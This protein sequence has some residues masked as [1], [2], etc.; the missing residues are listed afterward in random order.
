[1][2]KNR[3]IFIEIVS[4]FL[5][6]ALVY[7]PTLN[8]S[9]LF[10]TPISIDFNVTK[11]T[12]SLM[13]TL[14]GF[15]ALV[16]SLYSG[17]V[18]EGRNPYSVVALNLMI[19]S[20]SYILMSNTKSF[21]VFTLMILLRS[22][23]N[24]FSTVIPISII[25]NNNKSI[26]RKGQTLGVV[27]AGSGVGALILSPLSGFLI[28]SYSWRY[29]FLGYAFTSGLLA[30]M[31]YL[32]SKNKSNIVQKKISKTEESWN[33]KKIEY[34]K[35]IAFLS[36]AATY[37]ILAGVNQSWNING[38]SYLEEVGYSIREVSIILSIVALGLMIGKIIVG[39][40]GDRKG[41]FT[42]NIICMTSTLLGFSLYLFS[43]AKPGFVYPG[44]ILMGIGMS[45]NTIV[46]PLTVLE[47]FKNEDFA[48]LVGY[49]QVAASLGGSIIP[50]FVS[51]SFD[52]TGS[53]RLSWQVISLLI[54]VAILL[55]SKGYKS[56]L[57]K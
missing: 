10:V 13:L 53:Y 19:L 41:S 4:L 15:T 57:I 20:I 17:K 18:F 27:M 26:S 42:A 32:Q 46:Q 29:A 47:V 49:F 38:A 22:V 24:T 54:I 23:L 16:A 37:F 21:V 33:F 30:I 45:I 44:V 56:R 55:L 52:L 28:S 39:Y 25:I 6:M 40:I 43:F 31:V 35:K 12:V 8:I 11:G 34:S 50:I 14:S 5:L 1:M 7:V 51:Q 2:K 48:S 36:I 9:G 3:S